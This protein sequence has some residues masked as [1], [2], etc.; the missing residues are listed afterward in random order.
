[1]KLLQYLLEKIL[2]T[3]SSSNIISILSTILLRITSF[4]I[5]DAKPAWSS[6]PKIDSHNEEVVENILRAPKPQVCY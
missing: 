6:K 3:E 4:K 2:K 1:M 5:F